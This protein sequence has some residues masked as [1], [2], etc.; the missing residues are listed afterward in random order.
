M[1]SPWYTPTFVPS[2]F[3]VTLCVCFFNNP[4]VEDKPVT[5]CKLSLYV[6]SALFPTNSTVLGVITTLAVFSN[7]YPNLLF[8]A[9]TVTDVLVTSV[10]VGNSSYVSAPILYV[11]LNC[12]VMSSFS[13][14][15]A[16]PEIECA[17]PS[18]VPS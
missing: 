14:L 6:T 10:N 8:V 3:A 4:V 16:T 5:F 9:I 17:S 1:I 11:I 2:A 15:T 7:W 13:V 12:L 18:Y